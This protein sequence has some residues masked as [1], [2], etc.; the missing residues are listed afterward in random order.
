M[1][2]SAAVRALAEG[3]G[4]FVAEGRGCRLK[5]LQCFFSFRASAIFRVRCAEKSQ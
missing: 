4:R 2:E 5:Y 3:L 1:K